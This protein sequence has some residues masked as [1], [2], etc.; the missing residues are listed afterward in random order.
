HRQVGNSQENNLQIQWSGANNSLWYTQLNQ[1]YEIKA[2]KQPIGK[3]NEA[4]PFTSNILTFTSPVSF[5]LFSDGYADQFSPSDKKLLKK[6]FKEIILSMQH[7][8]IQEQ[9]KHL[10]KFH[11]EWKG[12]MEQ[13]DDVLVIGLKV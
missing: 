13:T 3:H 8:S 12:S 9:G 6:Q 7:L 2:D 1:L 11:S 5:Y 4:A 10:E